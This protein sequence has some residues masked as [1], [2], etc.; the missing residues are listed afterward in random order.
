M[1][2]SATG[3]TPPRSCAGSASAC[4]AFCG[5]SLDSGRSGFTANLFRIDLIYWFGIRETAGY[6]ILQPAP[7]TADRDLRP[8]TA[9]TSLYWRR[10]GFE[11]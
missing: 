10:E 3:P 9:H 6:Q 8:V 4:A 1:Q 2:V 5:I 11:E 7:L